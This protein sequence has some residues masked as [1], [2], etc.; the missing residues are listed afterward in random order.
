MEISGLLSVSEEI[1]GSEI[2]AG[3]S[4]VILLFFMPWTEVIWWS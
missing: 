1:C 2:W 4:W 3:L